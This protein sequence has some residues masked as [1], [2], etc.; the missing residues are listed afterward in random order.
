MADQDGYY[1]RDAQD[2][3]RGPLDDVEFDRLRKI[4]TIKSTFKVWRQKGGNIFKVNLER[5]YTLGRILS[6]QSCGHFF[7]L[8]MISTCLLMMVWIFRAP[9]LQEEMHKEN[10]D[11]TML[12]ILLILCVAM[13]LVTIRTNL[14]R[15]GEASS[16]VEAVEPPV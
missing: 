1:Y 3:T 15:L 11:G 8:L 7:E 13:T 4:G 14:K 10:G 9:K 12:E 2:R 6:L 5:K 16:T